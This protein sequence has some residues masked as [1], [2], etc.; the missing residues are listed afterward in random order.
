MGLAG[1]IYIDDS[2]FKII[3]YGL[4]EGLAGFGHEH[5]VT[6]LESVYGEDWK[7]SYKP[8]KELDID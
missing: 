5:T 8:V 6:A 4:Q 1:Q 2:N 7:I 3:V